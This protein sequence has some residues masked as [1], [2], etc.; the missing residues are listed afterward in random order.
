MNFFLQHVKHFGGRGSSVGSD[1]LWAGQY[2]DQIPVGGDF[3]C[4]PDQP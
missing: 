2:G 1:L 4:C 3:L